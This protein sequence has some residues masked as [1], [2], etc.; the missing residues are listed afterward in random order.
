MRCS[1]PPDLLFVWDVWTRA[2]NSSSLCFHGLAE[3]VLPPK[4]IKVPFLRL[5]GATAAGAGLRGSGLQAQARPSADCRSLQPVLTWPVQGGR[6]PPGGLRGWQ[7]APLL[8]AAEPPEPGARSPFP[9]P[10]PSPL[11]PAGVSLTSLERG[12]RHA[13]AWGNFEKILMPERQPQKLCSPSSRGSVY[14]GESH[15]QLI[16]GVTLELL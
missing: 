4:G 10:L 7:P 14:P 3:C 13:R 2:T 16:P 9:L 6:R 5:A 1:C 8:K 11:L 12:T 15:M